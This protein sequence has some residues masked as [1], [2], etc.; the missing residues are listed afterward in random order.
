MDP[1]SRRRRVARRRAESY[2]RWLV[3]GQLTMVVSVM[4][5]GAWLAHLAMGVT[6][7]WATGLGVLACVLVIVA[8]VLDYRYGVNLA[9]ARG[10]I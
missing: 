4:S 5:L 3:V 7:E 10:D 1:E 8:A 2:A 9:V 6:A